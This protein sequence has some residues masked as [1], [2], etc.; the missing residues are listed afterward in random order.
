MRIVKFEVFLYERAPIFTES[1]NNI[2]NVVENIC[3][4]T[5]D[6]GTS[7]QFDGSVG[8]EFMALVPDTVVTNL[9][10]TTN[11]MN[12]YNCRVLQIVKIGTKVLVKRGN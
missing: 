7:A 6:A 5:S 10:S 4:G 11:G 8:I 9:D 3:T 2:H 12:D 1:C